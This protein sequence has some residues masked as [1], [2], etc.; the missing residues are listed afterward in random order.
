MTQTYLPPAPPV[1]IRLVETDR[2][3]LS[4][5]F[6]R[7]VTNSDGL[8]QLQDGTGTPVV[9]AFGLWRDPA[10][11][12]TAAIPELE[13]RFS[14]VWDGPDERATLTFTIAEVANAFDVSLEI[15]FRAPRRVTRDALVLQVKPALA[16][17]AKPNGYAPPTPP[18]QETW[19]GRGTVAYGDADCRFAI[20]H[21]TEL[22]SIQIDPPERR[23]WLNFDWAEDHPHIVFSRSA[24]WDDASAIEWPAGARRHGAVRLYV[25][26]GVAPIVRPMLAPNGALGVFVWTEHACNCDLRTHRA[27]YFGHEDIVRAK[28][29]VGGFVK[30]RIPT[31]KSVF[32]D[33]EICERIAV[34]E[35]SVDGE[36]V[37]IRQNPEF[38]TYLFELRDAGG[39]EIIPH[40]VQPNT[41]TRDKAIEA[42][43]YM[44]RNFNSQSWIDHSAFRRNVVSGGNDGYLAFGLD[45]AGE[46]YRGDLWREFG[47]RYFWNH[48]TEYKEVVPRHPPPTSSSQRQKLLS[49]VK[50][51]LAQVL[52]R[53]LLEKIRKQKLET[54]GDQEPDR[55]LDQF[56]VHPARPMPIWWR[57]A[58]ATGEFLNWATRATADAYFRPGDGPIMRRRL[59]G[60]VACWGI[61][62]H[63]CY[64]TRVERHNATWCEDGDGKFVV[65]PA[66]DETLAHMAAL[67]DA[68]DLYIGTM[69]EL[70]GHWEALADLHVVPQAD[71][72][73]LL[74]NRSQVRLR[75]VSVAVRGGAWRI[76]GAEHH[77]RRFGTD[78]IL[79][80]D[81]S[82]NEQVKV[83]RSDA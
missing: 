44:R 31:T 3:W 5:P 76:D 4:A 22:S 39:Y 40:G 67:R 49:H 73:T 42:L 81:L 9:E 80:C 7:L 29:A 46:H 18:T 6:G 16:L 68:G 36:M 28:D 23:L 43:D 71:G 50:H 65:S 79:W 13:D 25:G 64:P 59:D 56:S 37:A 75:G 48:A 45:P 12:A 62:L 38:E 58:Q 55:A 60:L 83:V 11:V 34:R 51:A 54:R 78:W 82:P 69:R 21:P 1:D 52:P 10:P 35:A 70:M 53:G 47:Y 61:D 63:H 77:V 20:V 19:L 57:N 15:D 66:F 27:V 26:S 17:A 74:H 8:L 33:N 41:S 30:H 32:Y 2:V 24:N 72:T 14:L